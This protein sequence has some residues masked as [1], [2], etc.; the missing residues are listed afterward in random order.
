MKTFK[1][2]ILT[3][4]KELF[5]GNASLLTATAMDGEITILANHAPIV[6]LLSNGRV[7]YKDQKGESFE[8]RSE[9]GVIRALNNQVSVVIN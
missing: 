8:I 4:E 1:L 9:K 5:N 7:L 3:P 6:T 2:N